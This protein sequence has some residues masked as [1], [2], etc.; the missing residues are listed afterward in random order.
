MVIEIVRV[1]LETVIQTEKGIEN[2]GRVVEGGL[3]DILGKG[4]RG[5]L[6]TLGKVVNVPI[7]E[8]FGKLCRHLDLETMRHHDRS[9]PIVCH[10]SRII[11]WVQVG[12]LAGKLGLCHL[13]CILHH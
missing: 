3:D 2:V 6:V 5:S 9:R 10:C 12:W 4:H 8:W 11:T 13:G 7:D 1:C